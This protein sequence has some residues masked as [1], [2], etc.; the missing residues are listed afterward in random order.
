MIKKVSIIIENKI[1][2]DLTLKSFIRKKSRFNPSALTPNMIVL[3]TSKPVFSTE[4]IS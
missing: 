3:E 2:V 4:L 1:L